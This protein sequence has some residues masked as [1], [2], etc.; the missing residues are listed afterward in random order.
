MFLS[1]VLIL[2]LGLY[3]GSEYMLSVALTPNRDTIAQ[4]EY[5]DQ[6]WEKRPEV[7]EWLDSVLQCG[8][9]RDTFI[10]NAKGARLHAYYKFA[11]SLTNKTAIVVHGYKVRALGMAHIA[12]M[13][14]AD[15]H[16]NI[17]VPDLYAHGQSEGDAIQMGWFDRLDV[18]EWM[19]VAD[20]LFGGSTL[21]VVHGISMGAAT[22][23]MVSGENPPEARCYVEDCGYTSVWDEYCQEVKNS[24]PKAFYPLLYTSSWLCK[25][26]YGW[27]FKEASPE[28]QVAKCKKPMLFI[29][30]SADDFVPTAMVHG[31]Y[32]AKGGEKDLWIAEGSVHARSYDDYPVEY[33]QKVSEFLNKYMK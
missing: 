15:L 5:G 7:K 18:M 29:H 20:K 28:K 2:A 17:L 26:R 27:S 33:T 14:D 31:V 8:A 1:L 25:A 11:D 3:G 24:Y 21:Q 30:G 19:K 9:L 6:R 23:M 13:Y 4:F 12:K 32:A 10:V 16:Y 22:T